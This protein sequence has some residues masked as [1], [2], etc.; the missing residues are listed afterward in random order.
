MI[1][2]LQGDPGEDAD[3]I[4]S[5]LEHQQLVL[6]P[7]VLTELL[8]DPALPGSVRTLLAGLPVLELEPGF[9][10]R[11][12]MLRASVLKKSQESPDRRRI[13][14]PELPRSVHTP[15][16]SRQGLPPLRN[17]RTIAAV[18]AGDPY[19]SALESLRFNE[20]V[21]TSS[22]QPARLDNGEQTS[23]GARSARRCRTG[24]STPP[25]QVHALDE[26][27]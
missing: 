3:L 9:W 10:E 20:L 2:F 19:D 24:C 14:R 13:D 25:G 27:P 18:V 7:P 6:P 21:P 12:G 15:D 26:K 16:H 5:A 11:A 4:Q 17:R 8:S 1:A 22:F 23:S